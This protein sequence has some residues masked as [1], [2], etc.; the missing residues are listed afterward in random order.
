MFMASFK[1]HC[2]LLHQAEPA[3]VLHCRAP[4][5]PEPSPSEACDALAIFHGGRRVAASA[6]Q[7][8]P[9]GFGF[10]RGVITLDAAT[11]LAVLL[12]CWTLRK[13]SCEQ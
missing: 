9:T 2:A 1:P 5:A 7:V 11:P 3:S 13:V 6:L 4:L 12:Q 8:V 10:L